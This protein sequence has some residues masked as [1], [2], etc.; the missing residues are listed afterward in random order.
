MLFPKKRCKGSQNAWITQTFRSFFFRKIFYM[1][2]NKS[3]GR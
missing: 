3:Y 1:Q 2:K